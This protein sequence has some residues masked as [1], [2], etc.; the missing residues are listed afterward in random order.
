M[1]NFAT[2]A[3]AVQPGASRRVASRTLGVQFHNLG[4]VRGL[5]QSFK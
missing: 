5:A 3:P 2:D 4:V 1:R